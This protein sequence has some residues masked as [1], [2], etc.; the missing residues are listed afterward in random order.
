MEHG[1][2][3][4]YFLTLVSILHKAGKSLKRKFYFKVNN[5]EHKYFLEPTTTATTTK[6]LYIILISCAP[7]ALKTAIVTV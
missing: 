3:Q 7:I 6:G 1:I 4:K 2:F 5:V